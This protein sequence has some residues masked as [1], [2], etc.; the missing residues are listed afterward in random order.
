MPEQKEKPKDVVIT[1]VRNNRKSISIKWTQGTDEYDVTF[2]EN[3]LKSFY[4]ALDALNPHVLTLCEFSSKDLEKVRATGITIRGKADLPSALIVARKTIRKGKRVFNIATPLLP[5][6]ENP[7]N[8]GA[9]H[10]DEAEAKAIEK[11]IKEATRYVCGE[12]AQGQIEWEDEDGGE[13]EKK[14]DKGDPLP[15]L[16]NPPGGAQG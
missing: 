5:M 11:V 16:E 6:Y 4:N 1:S 15:G 12:R 14:G 3:P 10:M 2:H 9:D 8:K 13:D 7:E